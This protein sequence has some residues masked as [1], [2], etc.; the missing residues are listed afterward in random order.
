MEQNPD[1]KLE[2][3]DI[4]MIR[5]NTNKVLGLVN[6]LLELSKIDQGKLQLEPTEGDVYKC[7]RAAASSFSSHAAQRNMDYRVRI[8]KETLWAAYDRDKL[9]KSGL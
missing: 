9:E 6:Q 1:E 7:L 8:P 4:K 2:R 3:D 5:R